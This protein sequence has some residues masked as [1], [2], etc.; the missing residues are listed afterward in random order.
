MEKVDIREAELLV[1]QII[2]LV[3]ASNLDD[4]GV[5]FS[6]G[7]KGEIQWRV[8]WIISILSGVTMAAGL[9]IGD[10]L[11]DII[12][13]NFAIYI[14]SIVLASI[15]IWFIWQGLKPSEEEPKMQSGNIGWKAAF[16]LGLA[17]GI[18]SFA[19]GFSGGLTDFPIILTSV[20]AWLTSLIFVWLG[21][22]FAGAI[23]IKFVRDYAELFSGACFIL[24]ALVIL[25]F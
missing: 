13:G 14:A 18:D 21:S 2:V 25:I 23:S 10:E 12:P 19:A 1:W 9:I 8:I 20:L 4:L 7:I 15:G 11:A 24:L 16:I 22:T 6:L 3:V 17:L 5:G